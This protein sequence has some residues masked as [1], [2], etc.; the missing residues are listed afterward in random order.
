MTSGRTRVPLQG[1]AGDRF[2]MVQHG[3]ILSNVVQGRRLRVNGLVKSSGTNRAIPDTVSIASLFLWAILRGVR[4]ELQC[5]RV[6]AEGPPWGKVTELQGYG[7]LV[8][9]TPKGG[10]EACTSVPQGGFAL[11]C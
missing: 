6:R 8:Q 2:N 7:L 5:F 11:R 4:L 10:L 3:S 9:D 1:V